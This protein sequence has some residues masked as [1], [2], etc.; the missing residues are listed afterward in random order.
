MYLQTYMPLRLDNKKQ[1]LLRCY[2]SG[3]CSKKVAAL[4]IS[5]PEQQDKGASLDV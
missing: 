1:N 3:E 5:I 4:E 2:C